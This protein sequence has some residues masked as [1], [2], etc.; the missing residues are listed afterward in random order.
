MLPVR[1]N[2]NIYSSQ[3]N[4]RK[5]K[6]R[7]TCTFGPG[8]QRWPR[9]SGSSLARPGQEHFDLI[10]HIRIQVP[11]FVGGRVNHV[12]LSPVPRSGAVLHLLQDDG[13]VANDAVG[14]GFNPQVCGAHGEELR[15][16]DRGGRGCQREGWGVGHTLICYESSVKRAR[17]HTQPGGANSTPVGRRWN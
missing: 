5:R 4:K 3:T 17:T 7:P 16:C 12:G 2:S 9:W 10:L 15:W 14:I 1:H 8:G 6:G 11:Q 13:P